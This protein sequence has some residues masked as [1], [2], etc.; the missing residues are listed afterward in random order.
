ME[1]QKKKKK[2]KKKKALQLSYE[3]LLRSVQDPSDFNAQSQMLLA[4]TYAGI[5]FGNAG[6]HIWF[7][8]SFVFLFVF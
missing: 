7:L 8:S 1:N 3:Y 2:K 6:V 4:S 5:G